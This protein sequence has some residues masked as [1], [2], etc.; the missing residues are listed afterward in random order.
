MALCPGLPEWASSRKVKPIW[1]LLKQETVSGSGI[2]WVI[3]KSAPRSSQISTPAPHRSLFLQAR[4]PSFRLKSRKK[5]K[6]QEKTT[7][8]STNYRSNWIEITQIMA[9]TVYLCASAYR[10]R[11]LG[12]REPDSAGGFQTADLRRWV[13]PSQT[14]RS[15]SWP[16]RRLDHASPSRCSTSLHS[17]STAQLARI[18]LHTHT[19]PFKGPFFRDYP[20]EPLPER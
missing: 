15:S 20:G 7:T 8:K 11:Y 10:E 13:F 2:R 3:C 9:M 18:R 5:Q 12:W 4:Y 6:Q 1:I 14:R 19:H 17:I 16:G